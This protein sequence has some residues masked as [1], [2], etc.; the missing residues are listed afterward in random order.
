MDQPKCAA[1]GSIVP[2]DDLSDHSFIDKNALAG[3]SG[4]NISKGK[5]TTTA[6][7]AN[8]TR[9]SV[10]ILSQSDSGSCAN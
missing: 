8:K 9:K 5:A 7:A 3:T 10:T 1:K 2:E 4:I 6:A